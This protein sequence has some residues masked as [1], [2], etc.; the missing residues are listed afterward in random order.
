MMGVS[1]AGKTTLLRL[2]SGLDR[3][4][5]GTIQMQ[6]N[7]L[8]TPSQHICPQKRNVGMVFQH[9]ALF[10]H[11]RVIDNVMFGLQHLPASK[12]RM[13][14][15]DM[16]EKVDM[17]ARARDYPHQLSG[18]QHQ[19]VAL[20]R[21]LAPSPAL[22]LLDEAFSSLDTQL[23]VAI[24]EQTLALLRAEHV[25]ALVVTHDPQEALTMA[26][27]VLLLGSQGKLLQEGTPYDVYHQPVSAEA[28]HMLGEIVIL[29]VS[30]HA[31]VAHTVLGRL[32]VAYHGL[33]HARHVLLRPE[34]I[35]LHTRYAPG[36][37]EATVQRIC[38]MGQYT[39]L[40]MLCQHV[41]VTCYTTQAV[42]VGQIVWLEANL[43]QA[44][45]L[46]AVPPSARKTVMTDDPIS[47][48]MPPHMPVDGWQRACLQS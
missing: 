5:S 43:Q 38:Y 1:G 40:E 44:I 3:L 23:R 24:R 4:Q 20:A 13:R 26:D 21:A 16:L 2:I 15:L 11:M 29:P 14:A 42:A 45:Q 32:P 19:R 46:E 8:A 7:W 12:A 36:Y 41:P 10:P 27:R 37:S 17:A 47:S 30:I 33:A 22:L 48:A 18:G 34:W 35:T 28:A 31:G 6:D 9:P 25:A 39:K